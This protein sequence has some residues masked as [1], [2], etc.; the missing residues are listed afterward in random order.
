M[1]KVGLRCGM[2]SSCICLPGWWGERIRCLLLLIGCSRTLLSIT[3]EFTLNSWYQCARF[4]ESVR[5]SSSVVEIKVVIRLQW[6]RFIRFIKLPVGRGSTGHLNHL[7]LS[8]LY[9]SKKT[10]LTFLGEAPLDRKWPFWFLPSHW[11][12]TRS[13]VEWLINQRV[14]GMTSELF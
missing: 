9:L 14:V 8:F 6:G 2:R 7:I 10:W 3:A 12:K 5:V 4:Y 1:R 11:T 13:L